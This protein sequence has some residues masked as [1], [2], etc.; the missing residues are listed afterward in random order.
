MVLQELEEVTRARERARLR[1]RERLE[2]LLASLTRQP[3][4][5]RSKDGAIT[6]PP[7]FQDELASAIDGSREQ[8][9]GDLHDMERDGLI[10]RS[11]GG[12]MVIPVKSPLHPGKRSATEET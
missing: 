10:E 4:I 5:I 8:V 11:P 9:S 7:L 2:M 1:A 6:L 12:R 3:V